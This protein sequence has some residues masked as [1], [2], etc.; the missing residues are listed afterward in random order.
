MPVDFTF[1]SH[2]L[3]GAPE[4]FGGVLVMFS[5]VVACVSVTVMMKFSFGVDLGVILACFAIPCVSGQ[6][7]EPGEAQC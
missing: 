5:G 1:H 4:T 7:T 3:L 2:Y 6:G